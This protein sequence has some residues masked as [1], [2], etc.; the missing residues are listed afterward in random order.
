MQRVRT[1][2][3]LVCCEE[4]HEHGQTYASHPSL[5]EKVFHIERRTQ[6]K[7]RTLMLCGAL[8]IGWGIGSQAV[9]GGSNGISLP[10]GHFSFTA[11]GTEASCAAGACITLNIIEAGNMVRDSAGNACGSHTAVVT[12]V[13]ATAGSPIVV[14]SVI[15]VLNLLS[16]DPTT[17][18][19]DAALSEYSGGSCRGATF[20]GTGATQIVSGSLHFTVSS[21]ENGNGGDRID[22]ILT[23]HHSRGT[24]PELFDYL[25]GTAAEKR[26]EL[27][28]ARASS[29]N[30]TGSPRDRRRD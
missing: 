2:R 13:P 5:A 25:H 10:S 27:A 18:T 3:K 28:A 4:F 30:D 26:R 6:L 12:T 9:A 24:G 8:V 16:Y 15:T 20:N 19:G 14:P 1:S 7:T 21:G 17:G 23:P 11:Q 22:S 29:R